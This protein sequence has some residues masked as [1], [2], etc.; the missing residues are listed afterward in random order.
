MCQGVFWEI[1][2]EAKREINWKNCPEMRLNEDPKREN[3]EKLDQQ[4]LMIFSIWQ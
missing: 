3:L 1:F 4:D 2:P